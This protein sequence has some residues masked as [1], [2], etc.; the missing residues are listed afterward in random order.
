MELQ[1]DP[2]HERLQRACDLITQVADDLD[3]QL[4]RQ[5]TQQISPTKAGAFLKLGLHVES[6]NSMAAAIHEIR[7]TRHLLV[8]RRG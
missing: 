7:E 1:R 5:L 3:L 6:L 2:N 4:Q 8:T